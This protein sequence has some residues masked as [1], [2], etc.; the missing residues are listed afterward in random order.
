MITQ[1]SQL[2]PNGNY[3]YA[4]YLTWQFDETVELFKGKLLPISPAPSL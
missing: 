4:D 2:D 3:T 1:P